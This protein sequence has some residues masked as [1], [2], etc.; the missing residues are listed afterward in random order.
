ML[1]LPPEE[2]KEFAKQGTARK[3]VPGRWNRRCKGSEG[4]RVEHV[5]HLPHVPEWRGDEYAHGGSGA[6]RN[7]LQ[8]GD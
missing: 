3:N 4:G 7:D 8:P 6:Q 2:G 1:P 5:R